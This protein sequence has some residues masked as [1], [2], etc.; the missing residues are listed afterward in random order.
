MC[1]THIHPIDFLFSR[2]VFFMRILLVLFFS[3]GFSA[4]A[5]PDLHRQW[6]RSTL[7]KPYLHFRHMNRMSP[8]LTDELVIQGNAVEGIKAFGRD[9]GRKIWSFSVRNGVEGGA[10]LDG[11]NLYFGAGD[12]RFYCLS[13]QNGAGSLEVSIELRVFDPTFGARSLCLPYYWQQYPLFFWTKKLA[14][15]YGSKPMLPG[16]T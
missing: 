15:L 7:N 2:L 10:V 6:S 3:L 8:I 16:Q 4:M 13:V 11:D 12:G 1:A 5:K 9:S 14:V